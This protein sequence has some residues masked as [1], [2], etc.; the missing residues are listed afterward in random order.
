[1]EICKTCKGVGR[2]YL[3]QYD[4]HG[5]RCPNC[6]GTGEEPIKVEVNATDS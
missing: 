3:G 4:E 1:M 2:L 5:K 6:K